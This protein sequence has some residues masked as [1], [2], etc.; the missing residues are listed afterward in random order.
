MPFI[1]WN[2]DA[3]SNLKNKLKFTRVI[4]LNDLH[5]MVAYALIPICINRILNCSFQVM[6]IFFASVFMEEHF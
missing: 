6:V 4:V 3:L 2:H 5:K 1:E